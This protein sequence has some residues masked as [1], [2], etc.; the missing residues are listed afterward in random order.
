MCCFA[1]AA[2]VGMA[3]IWKTN[4][5]RPSIF[6]RTTVLHAT[7]ISAYHLA[8]LEAFHHADAIP[9]SLINYLWPACLIL[10]GNLFFGLKSGLAGYVGVALGCCAIVVLVDGDSIQAQ[11]SQM[12]GYAL[13]LAGAV[14]WALFSNLR[15]HNTR[16]PIGDMTAICLLSTVFCGTSWMVTGAILPDLNLMDGCVIIALGL[17]PA[18]GAFYLWDLGMRG[19]NAVLLGVLGYSAPVISTFL[20]LAVGIGTFSWNIILAML[21]ITAGGFIVHFANKLSRSRLPDRRSVGFF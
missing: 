9:V 15:R 1:I 3:V 8:Y 12:T 2:L 4:R 10:L 18:G 19:G 16:E 21:L 7:V 11:S 14:L 13:A 20:M 5:P 6:N 17:G